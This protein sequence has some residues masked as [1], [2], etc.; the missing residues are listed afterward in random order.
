MVLFGSVLTDELIDY[1][2]HW[3]F[4]VQLLMAQVVQ[5]S[6]MLDYFQLPVSQQINNM[7]LTQSIAIDRV[8]WSVSSR[9]LQK[10]MNGSICL[11]GG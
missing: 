9:A 5:R 6:S 1:I 7:L 11:F 2:T 4:V 8:A 10:W 3:Y